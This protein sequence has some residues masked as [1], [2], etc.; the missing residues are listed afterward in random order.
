L[1]PSDTALR[2][3]KLVVAHEVPRRFWGEEDKRNKEDWPNPLESDWNPVSPCIP[4]DRLGS[5]DT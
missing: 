1:K 3:F 2:L 4:T 5:P